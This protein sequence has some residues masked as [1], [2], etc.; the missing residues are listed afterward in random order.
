MPQFALQLEIEVW[1]VE[2]VVEII[3]FVELSFV[4]LLHTV[5]GAQS[6]V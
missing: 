5:I 2:V 6:G 3:S 1:L 4:Q